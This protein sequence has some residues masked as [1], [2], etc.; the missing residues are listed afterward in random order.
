MSGKGFV[1]DRFTRLF[2]L[3]VL[4]LFSAACPVRGAVEPSDYELRVVPASISV[5]PDR[6][7]KGDF[8]VRLLS[9]VED[10]QGWSFGVILETSGGATGAITRVKIA[11]DTL[12]VNGGAPPDFCATG[13]YLPGNLLQKESDCDPECDDIEAAAVTQGVVISFTSA[14]TLPATDSFGLVD[15]TVSGTGPQGSKLRL[16]FTDD[17]GTPPVQTVMVYEGKSIRPA[18]QESGALEFEPHGEP[19][20]PSFTIDIADAEGLCGEETESLVTLNFNA[21]G[22][23]E[24]SKV[25]GWSYG[26]CVKDPERAQPVSAT[27]DG[28]D[29][30]QV[31]NGSPPDYNVTE[32]YPQGVTHAVV[33]DFE[34]DATLA[35]RNDWADLRV[36]Y[37]LT[38]SDP[39]RFTYV[40][41]CDKTL[42]SPPM[43]NVVVVDGAP[44]PSSRF[45]GTDPTDPEACPWGS[46]LCNKPGK[47]SCAMVPSF[48]PGDANGDRRLDIADGIF[49]LNYLFQNG[50]APGC[51]AACDFNDDGAID[52]SDA[53]A[54]IFWRLQPPLPDRPPEGWPGPA[55]GLGCAPHETALPCDVPC[56]P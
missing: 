25:Q 34:G 18:V 43:V 41:P 4:V 45:E 54:L 36:T 22:S 53:V 38:M 39:D 3:K 40:T 17:V 1:S 56:E 29:T 5:D 27:T 20:P 2:V 14:A 11:D 9:K 19:V 24:G 32:L 26:L 35:A 51:L 48:R 55:F 7:G 28:T 15:I 12:T 6:S 13:Y 52:G 30:A 47:L 10:T 33:I 37:R 16:D 8:S 21:D 49:I 50:P 31:K 42:G 44:I 23:M 46:E